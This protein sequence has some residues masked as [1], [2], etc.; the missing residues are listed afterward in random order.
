MSEVGS[1]IDEVRSELAG[2]AGEFMPDTCSITKNPTAD[3]GASG[4]TLVPTTSTTNIPC[5][6]K[7][8]GLGSQDV[9]GGDAQLASHRLTL[10][11][12]QA[13]VLIKPEDRITVKARGGYPALVFQRP[14]IVNDSLSVF[15]KVNATLAQ[16][17]YG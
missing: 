1:A 2:V 13:T 5:S 11:T 4:D 17:G 7:S 16:Q 3:G 8:L 6:Y 12:T 14:V 9:V 10:P 15:V